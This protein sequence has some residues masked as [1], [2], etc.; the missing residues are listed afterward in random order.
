[1]TVPTNQSAKNQTLS[2][3]LS[4]AF[5]QSSSRLQNVADFVSE[6]KFLSNWLD[7]EHLGWRLPAISKPHDWCGLW[8][9]IGCVNVD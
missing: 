6:H 7:V 2:P 9:T 5:E 1:M 4:P 3:F 8:K